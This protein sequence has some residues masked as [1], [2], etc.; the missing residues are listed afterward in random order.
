MDV[1]VHNVRVHK[2]GTRELTDMG[3]IHT[4]EI[5]ECSGALCTF[6]LL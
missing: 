5:Q 3:R 4:A 6:V 2:N 1:R